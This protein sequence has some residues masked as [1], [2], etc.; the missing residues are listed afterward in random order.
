MKNELQLLSNFTPSDY[1]L[2]LQPHEELWN[3]IK[4][5]KKEFAEKFDAPMAEWTKPHIT[6][7]KFTQYEMME[8]RII[9]RLKSISMGLPAFKVEMKDFGSFPSHT[10]YINILSKIPIVNA[11]KA[12]RQAQRLMKINKDIT[13]HF[14]TEPHLTICRK[15]LPWQ[16]EKAWL[17]YEHKNFTGRFIAD[18][19]KLLRKRAGE[20]Q[21]Y[22]TIGDFGFENLPVVTKQGELFAPA[23]KGVL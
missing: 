20:R 15:L 21:P 3:R 2:I 10:I 22:I 1:L 4:N 8:Q 18:K 11:V 12:V 19:M 9:N 17:E 7:A 14:I 13:P 16:Y 6:I 23:L 5:L